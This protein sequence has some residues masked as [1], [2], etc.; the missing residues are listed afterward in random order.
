M[1]P[2]L[3]ALVFLGGGI[4]SVLRYLLGGHFQRA[5]SGPFPTGT[6][7]VNLAGCLG[8]GFVGALGLEKAALSPE[9]RVF[10]MA[11]LLGGFTT[12][13]TFAWETLGLL[14][15]RDLFRAGLYA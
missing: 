13:S 12:F 15:V 11:G 4:G 5:F 10:L 14:T 7:V 1:R 9:A 8:I 6:F 2:A 3:L